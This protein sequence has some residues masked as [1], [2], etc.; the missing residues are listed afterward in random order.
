M[1]MANSVASKE[2]E[3]K[4]IKT[5]G[6]AKVYNNA[7]WDLVDA[8]ANGAFD[9]AAVD[10]SA[11]PDS[12][13]TKT[14]EE[15]KIIVE[16]KAKERAAVQSQIGDVSTKREAFIVAEKARR[17]ANK[18]EP[19]LETEVEKIIKEQARKYHMVIQ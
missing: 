15:L 11:L 1:D 2:G 6:N 12:L 16:A 18:N 9:F 13:K 17:A 14:T 4:R 19:T 7:Q 5:K 10:K 8:K 3:M